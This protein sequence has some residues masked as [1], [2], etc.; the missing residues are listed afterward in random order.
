MALTDPHPLAEPRVL[1]FAEAEL[2]ATIGLDLPGRVFLAGGV[3]K[4]LLHGRPPRDLDLWSPT[5]DDRTALV[6][7]LLDRGA[8]RGNRHA[9]ADVFFLAGREIEVPDHAEPPTLEGRLGRFDLALSAVGVELE[10]GRLRAVVHPLACTSV[11]RREVLLLQPLVNGKHA[12]G[13]LARAHRY[14]QELGWT[15]PLEEESV[16]WGL[17]DGQPV[18]EQERMIERYRK[19]AVRGWG[20]VEE[21]EG[22]LRKRREA[23]LPGSL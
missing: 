14:A 19:T 15:F 8:L 3:F 1:A 2:T 4:T 7:R 17:F 6:Q 20:V 18:E 22:R 13:T 12:L 11:D 9:Y 21:A 5:P 10:G 23:G 16:I